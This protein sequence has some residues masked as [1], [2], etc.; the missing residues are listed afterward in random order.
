MSNAPEAYPEP[1]E[2]WQEDE[3]QRLLLQHELE[4]AELNADNDQAETNRIKRA[5]AK[6]DPTRGERPTHISKIIPGVLDQRLNKV[7][8]NDE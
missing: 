2:N 1:P 8:D 6:L 7:H 4:L 5:V 3:V